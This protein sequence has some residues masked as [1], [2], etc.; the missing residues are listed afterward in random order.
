MQKSIVF[1]LTVAVA[2][3]GLPTM[4]L[5]ATEKPVVAKTAVVTKATPT[6][7][8]VAKTTTKPAVKPVVKKVEVEE[9]VTSTASTL[10]AKP[11]PTGSIVAVSTSAVTSLT[12][13]C[14]KAIQ[15]A[16]KFC[17]KI[18]AGCPSWSETPKCVKANE[19][20]DVKLQ[21]A[22]DLCPSIEQ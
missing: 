12:Q 21:A 18:A 10:P 7:K 20:C 2:V 14:N 5:A 9:V 16:N 17:K 13:S 3:L 22:M 11:L 8:V 6:K 1:I 4:S 19:E 15:E